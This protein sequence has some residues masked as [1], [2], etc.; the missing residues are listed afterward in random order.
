MCHRGSECPGIVTGTQRRGGREGSSGE[1]ELKLDPGR[2]AELDLGKAVSA[3]GW[4][5]GAVGD[6]R[7]KRTE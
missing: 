7:G 3:T 4:G 6:F 2:P 1:V 5:A